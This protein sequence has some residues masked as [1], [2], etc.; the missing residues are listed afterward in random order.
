MGRLRDLARDEREIQRLRLELRRLEKSDFARRRFMAGYHA[1]L[2]D[3]G[4]RP[5]QL[6]MHPQVELDGIEV[7]EGIA[8]LLRALWSLGIATQ[9]SCQGDP[10]RYIRHQATASQHDWVCCTDR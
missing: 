3:V 8:D 7:D 5:E 10:D 1:A 2:N 9:F 4:L 6:E